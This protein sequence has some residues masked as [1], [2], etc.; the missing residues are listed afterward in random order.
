MEG[1]RFVTFGIVPSELPGFLA[2]RGLSL[3]SDLGAAEYRKRSFGDAAH[4]MRGHE[5]YRVALASV[6]QPGSLAQERLRGHA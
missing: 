5:F 2:E 3:E 1:L 4:T 6:G